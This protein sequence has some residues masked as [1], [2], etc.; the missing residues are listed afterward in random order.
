[1]FNNW[2]E[3]WFPAFAAIFAKGS[4]RPIVF[5]T[6]FSLVAV[7]VI[8]GL[9]YGFSLNWFNVLGLCTGIYTFLMVLLLQYTQYRSGLAIQIKLDEIIRAIQ[10]AENSVMNIEELTQQEIEEKQVKLA[11]IAKTAREEEV[12]LGSLLGSSS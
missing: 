3:K 12:A 11:L 9:F 5:L 10:G 8:I 2:T 4:G 1:M 6:A 7:W